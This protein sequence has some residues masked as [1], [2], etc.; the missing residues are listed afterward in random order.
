M[1]Y[2]Y[3]GCLNSY[4]AFV[5]KS[6]SFYLKRRGRKKEWGRRCGEGEGKKK[7]TEKM[8]GKYTTARTSPPWWWAV[9]PGTYTVECFCI[10]FAR[11]N[12]RIE[13]TEIHNCNN[14]VYVLKLQPLQAICHCI[15]DFAFKEK[16]SSPR[17][18]RHFI[19]SNSNQPLQ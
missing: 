19:K 3:L 16:Q 9:I 10:F 11:E 15:Q 12:S 7:E 4:T 18:S 13:M 6:L 1:R 17:S 5:I 2:I 8:R 14:K